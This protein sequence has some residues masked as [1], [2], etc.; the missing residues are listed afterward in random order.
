MP[1]L[2]II[3][4]ATQMVVNAAVPPKE[5]D[6]YRYDTEKFDVLLSE[7]GGIGWALIDGVLTAPD[8]PDEESPPEE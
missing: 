4:K 7:T 1:V 8:M 6:N 2:L 3:D 5:G